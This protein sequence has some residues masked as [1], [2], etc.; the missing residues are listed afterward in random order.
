MMKSW[1]QFRYAL[2]V[3][4]P[5]ALTYIALAMGFGVM[6][7]ANGYNWVWAGAL[8]LF[9]YSGSIQFMAPIMLASG[10]D[11]LGTA[12][13]TLMVNF[14]L[15]FYGISQLQRYRGIQW[16]K[17]LYL[18][19]A[20]TD[21]TFSLVSQD[22][23]PVGIDQERFYFNVT[24]LNHFFWI[25]G[26][27]LGALVGDLLPFSTQG[28]EFS[29]TALF[30]VVV[31]NQWEATQNHRP[32][33]YGVIG[34]VVMLGLLGPDQFIVPAMLAAITMILVEHRLKGGRPDYV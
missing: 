9:V 16:F 24:L 27:I 26:S 10:A 12:I 34:G 2:Q 3:D 18:I 30:L 7:T 22:Y 11:L 21:E 19:F 5:I 14:R 13:L 28:I 1:E 6:M 4:L 32:A 31:I 20:L 15:L 23:L 17:K 33:I 25:S 8:S 29:L